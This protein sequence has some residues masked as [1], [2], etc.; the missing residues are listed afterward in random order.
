MMIQTG[1]YLLPVKKKNNKRKG[2]NVRISQIK[3]TLQTPIKPTIVDN[4]TVIITT[5]T[6]KSHKEIIII[7]TIN[8]ITVET[9]IDHRVIHENIRMRVITLS[10]KGEV[11]LQLVNH[12][13]E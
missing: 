5:I 12:M 4:T 9:I 7:A 2:E 6:I 11:D 1:N 8:N 3:I 13:K 10:F